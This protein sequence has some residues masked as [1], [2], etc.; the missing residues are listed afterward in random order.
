MHGLASYA[1]LLIILVWGPLFIHHQQFASFGP[2]APDAARARLDVGD[3]DGALGF[4]L[5][6]VKFSAGG[7][8]QAIAHAL[9]AAKAKAQ[10][11]RARVMRN[12]P[13]ISEADASLVAAADAVR[14]DM[15]S[16]PSMLADRGK[17]SL[18]REAMEGG[19]EV[20]CIRCGGLVARHRAEAHRT[21]W[22]PRLDDD[23]VASCGDTDR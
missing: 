5:A 1:D 19:T 23:E 21:T 22:C 15:L 17:S 12:Y 18:L 10:E 6:A 14:D 2:T 9:D 13:G 8:F 4:A 16:R 3:A 11:D 20:V 7:N